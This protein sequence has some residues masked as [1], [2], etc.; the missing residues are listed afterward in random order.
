[1]TVFFLASGSVWSLLVLTYIFFF[2]KK[3]IRHEVD[4]VTRRNAVSPLSEEKRG[5]WIKEGNLYSFL[6]FS[7]IRNFYI[8]FSFN[9]PLVTRDVTRRCSPL[10]LIL[11]CVREHERVAFRWKIK[12]VREGK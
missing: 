5:R 4:D 2:I 3:M 12:R 6:N 9:L 1:M 11:L 8:Y 7:Y 10:V